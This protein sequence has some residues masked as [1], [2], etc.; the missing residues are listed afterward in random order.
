MLL[1][2]RYRGSSFVFTFDVRLIYWSEKI[3]IT[4]MKLLILSYDLGSSLVQVQEP[5]F[6]AECFTYGLLASGFVDVVVQSFLGVSA[7]CIYLWTSMLRLSF[8]TSLLHLFCWLFTNL[9]AAI[10]F[11]SF[12]TNHRRR[13]RHC[14]WLGWSETSVG[15]FSRFHRF[16]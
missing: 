2:I 10:W 13:W 12:Y 9:S 5:M 16:S 15:S 8:S 14:N 1:V 11:S 7:E 4:A 3:P 6:G